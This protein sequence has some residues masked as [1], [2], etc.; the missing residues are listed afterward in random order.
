MSPKASKKCGEAADLYHAATV[1]AEFAAMNA[2]DAKAKNVAD[3]G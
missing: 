1:K 2:V 3:Q